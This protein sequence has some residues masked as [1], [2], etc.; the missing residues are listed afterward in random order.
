MFGCTCCARQGREGYSVDIGVWDQS[1][2][3]KD[4]SL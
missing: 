4:A 1:K 3:L 2:D